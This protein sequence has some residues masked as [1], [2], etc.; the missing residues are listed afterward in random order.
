M[1]VRV[2]SGPVLRR[3]AM[4]VVLALTAAAIG[5]G[6]MGAATESEDI[7]RGPHGAATMEYQQ[8]LLDKLVADMDVTQP[9]P[10]FDPV[11][12]NA[13]IP[14][15]N[16]M[17]ARRVALGRQLYFDTRLSSDGTVSCATCHDVTRA[18][19]DQ[20]KV[21]EGVEGQLGQRNAPTVMN[22][23]LLQS[24]FWDGRSPSL[25]HQA[26]F[27]IIN[28]IEMGMP[29]HE[30]VVQKVKGIP[31]Y[32]K[33]F[34]EA[35]GREVTSEDIGKAIGAFERTMV[36]MDSPFLRFLQGDTHAISAEARAGWE[37]FNGRA[38]CNACH[39]INPSNPLGSDNRFHNVGVSARHQDFEALSD[40]ALK[41][42]EED[43]SEE[44]VDELAVG[45]DL[46]ELGRFMVTKNRAEMGS[47]RTP[48]LLNIGITPP[49]MHDGSMKTLWD[50][51][52]HYNK[53]GESNPFLDGGIEPLA[54]TES[55]IDQVVALL[56]TMT[57]D[58]FA[59]QNQ[60]QFEQQRA[61]AR[62]ERPF[63]DKSVAFRDMLL[64]EQRVAGPKGLSQ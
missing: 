12:W 32:R 60:A 10:E 27:P 24:L 18:F 38:R 58:R 14:E 34:K 21:S 49:Y 28:P 51:M 17:T 7:P 9:P 26:R 40:R 44:A 29:D 33:A 36:F 16:E 1:A 57:D 47:F 37:L 52:D 50:V 56:F 35:Y 62:K 11:I 61:I 63:R 4:A 42:M 3:G 23:A 5:I 39:P 31:E 15:G 55:E 64:F 48:I 19:T 54:L 41:A 25:D 59:D 2:R 53:G 20:Q 22:A 13:F 46:S 30:A 45:T 6:S 43:A 8:K